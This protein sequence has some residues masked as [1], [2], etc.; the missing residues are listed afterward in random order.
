MALGYGIL[1]DQYERIPAEIR[2]RLLLE[3]ISGKRMRFRWV[4]SGFW[5][6]SRPSSI[7]M[8]HL[9]VP[10]FGLRGLTPHTD[11]L[12]LLIQARSDGALEWSDCINAKGKL[13]ELLWMVF[14]S[15]CRIIDE[16]KACMRACPQRF[17]SAAWLYWI[18]ER[19]LSRTTQKDLTLEL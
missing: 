19:V 4:Q 7:P 15:Q 17:S 10:S 11:F 12:S 16:W 1:Y 14:V 18:A 9:P 2:R 8:D 13:R 3:S 5:L 6:V